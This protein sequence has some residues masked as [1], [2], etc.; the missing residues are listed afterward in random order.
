M[1]E[2]GKRLRRVGEMWGSVAVFELYCWE[3]KQIVEQTKCNTLL[4]YDHL[5]RSKALRVLAW[6]E[7]GLN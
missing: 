5:Y 6:H 7:F 3:L 4:F 2:E 1:F